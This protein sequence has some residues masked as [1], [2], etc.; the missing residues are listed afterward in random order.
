[1]TKQVRLKI[2]TKFASDRLQYAAAGFTIDSTCYPW[3]A[4]KGPRFAPD[5]MAEIMTDKESMLMRGFA[6]SGY[7]IVPF[8]PSMNMMRSGNQ[9][10]RKGGKAGEVWAAM[11]EVSKREAFESLEGL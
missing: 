8:S 9:K 11:V 3:I 7:I 2:D 1:M 4:Y 5:E 10:M 6:E